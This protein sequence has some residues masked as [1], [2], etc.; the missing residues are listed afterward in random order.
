MTHIVANL[1]PKGLSLIIDGDPTTINNSHKNFD[2]ILEALRE[3]DFDVIPDLLN[4][5]KTIETLSEGLIKVEHGVVTYAG[6]GLH[7]CVT[8]R[9]LQTISLGL[10]AKPLARFLNRLMENPSYHSVEQLYSFMEACDLPV[11]E[12]GRL[13]A[14]K[15]V[16]KNY[17]DTHTSQTALSIPPNTD[18]VPR[19][20]IKLFEECLDG[21]F[22]FTRSGVTSR[23]SKENRMFVE[24]PRN[25]VDDNPN[26]TC[27]NGLHVCSQHYGMYGSLLLLVAVDPSDVVA[28][29]NDYN[30]AK[31]RVCRYEVLKNVDNEGFR[32]FDD[33]PIYSDDDI[34][35]EL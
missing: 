19:E 28:V 16:N 14:Y 30:Q 22:R 5:G 18:D 32:T 12:D 24:M 15:S 17:W 31:M 9:L 35:W 21:D 23:L 13:L 1:T 27:S 34:E 26:K 33:E 7:N 8:E 11:T 4:L 10:D 2:Q 20:T 6:H 29:P 25:M 3:G